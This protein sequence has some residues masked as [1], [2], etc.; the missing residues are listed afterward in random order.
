MTDQGNVEFRSHISKYVVIPK[1]GPAENMYFLIV[2]VMK[3]F[4]CVELE[5]PE[6][7]AEIYMSEFEKQGVRDK[8]LNH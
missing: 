1:T 4:L 7:D 2:E 6:G 5:I 8:N 3:N